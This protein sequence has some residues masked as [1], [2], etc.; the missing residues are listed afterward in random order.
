[1]T[2]SFP[3]GNKGA[4]HMVTLSIP[5]DY[6]ARLVAK[7]RGVQAREAEVDRDTGSNAADDHMIDAVQETPGDLS[8]EEIGREIMGLNER[9]QSELVALLGQARGDAEP[10]AWEE[11]VEMARERR[12]TPTEHYLLGQPLAAEHCAE[13]L[14]IALGGEAFVATDD[15]RSR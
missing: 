9:Q 5:S 13:R 11:T 4:A 12:D 3:V 10:E 8:R 1:M 7:M 15:I 14:G 6:P 2:C